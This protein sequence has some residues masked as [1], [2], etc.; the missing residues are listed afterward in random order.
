MAVSGSPTTMGT[1]CSSTMIRSQ[2]RRIRSAAC[3]TNMIVRPSSWNGPHALEALLLERLVADREH[4]V[5]EQDV[6]LDVDGDGEAE[7]H[8]HARR[9][10]LHR[11]VDELL[12]LGEGDDL[13]EA[14]LDVALGQAED[15]AVEVDVLAPGELG[16][17]A[18]AQLE[19]R[20]HP[21]AH[22]DH[23]AGG[24]RGSRRRT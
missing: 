6:G 5:D 2:V 24:A 21:P 8:V 17:E 12:E 9:V 13:V 18:G 10:V 3:D 14:R 11:R 16:V 1:P 23:A 20:R 19:Q 7:A 15:R 4:L 22:A